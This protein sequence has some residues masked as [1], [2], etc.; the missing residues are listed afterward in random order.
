MSALDDY[1]AELQRALPQ[2]VEDVDVSVLAL[3][4]D[5]RAI[6]DLLEMSITKLALLLKPPK[7]SGSLSII[8]EDIIQ[9][10]QCFV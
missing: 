1:S 4:T 6:L 5:Y 9:Q 7:T 10:V 8:M 3:I 2:P